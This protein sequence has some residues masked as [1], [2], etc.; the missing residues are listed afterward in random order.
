MLKY[1]IK[2]GNIDRNDLERVLLTET[3][4]LDMPIVVSNDGFRDN[5]RRPNKSKDLSRIIENLIFNNIEKYSIPYRYRIRLSSTTSRQLSLTHP[6]AQF[7]ATKFYFH[8][9]HMI[10]YF[11]RHDDISLRRPY[12]I[13]STAF[14]LTRASERKRYKGAAIDVLLQDR[15]VRNPGSFFAY[16]G[17][18]RFHK[19]FKSRE[20]TRLEKKFSIMRITDI[21]K[22]FSSIYS[23]TLAW[24]IKDVQHGKEN[25]NAISFANEFDN[26]MQYSNYNETNGIPVG[27]EL[28]RIF[29]EIILQSADIDIIKKADKNGLR[30]GE[31]FAIRRYIDDYAI[32]A[33]SEDVQDSLQRG[34]QESLGTFNLHLNDAKTYT[35]HRPLQTRKSQIIAHATKGLT[36]FRDRV[37]TLDRQ[38]HICFPAVVR[39]V[40]SLVNS[41]VEDMRAACLTAQSGY[42]EISSYVIGSLEN[43]VE[44]LIES[45]DKV[46]RI[47]NFNRERYLKSFEAIL[48][49]VYFFFAM[50]VTVADSYRVA[51]ITI[52]IIRFIDKKIPEISSRIH[53]IVRSMIVDVTTNP[54]LRTINMSG[55][56]PIEVMNI[57]LASKELSTEFKPNLDLI[58][59][60]VLSDENIDYFSYISM[61]FYNGNEDSVFIK[62]VEKEILRRF[63]PNAEPRLRSHDAHFMLDL[64]SCPYLSEDFRM[65]I[66]NSLYISLGIALGLVIDRKNL[67]KEIEE[68]PWFVNW[69]QIDLLNHLRKKELI[70]IY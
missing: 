36:A 29:A 54:A 21:S 51:K 34:L 48:N 33:H 45:F 60:R 28:S 53:E 15:T 32:F 5:I 49:S 70:S 56:V 35:L 1:K 13:G 30:H 52:L 24:A 17:Y 50:H 62:N 61:L 40:S 6:A 8:Y 23:H 11:C 4:P 9:A 3:S 19:F 69:T 57:V 55:Y 39:N 22:C 67:L 59:K 63:L 64:I 26:L 41:L 58:K 18:D 12:K 38:E 46:S 37:S 47:P 2:K 7:R 43:T 66:I 31:D 20:F 27:A 10:P 44:F 16:A 65:K 14:H 25:T 42:D 68:N